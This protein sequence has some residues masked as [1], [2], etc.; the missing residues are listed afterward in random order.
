MKRG[1][2]LEV[3]YETT[4]PPI[5]LRKAICCFT[6]YLTRIDGSWLKINGLK[7]RP[8]SPGFITLH[9]V[10]NASSGSVKRVNFV[11]YMEKEKVFNGCFRRMGHAEDWKMNCESVLETRLVG[12]E[13]QHAE[14]CVV[15][16]GRGKV[17]MMS[18]FQEPQ[19]Q[20]IA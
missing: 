13:L 3:V 9:M 18:L 19:A 6:C 4:T 7:I 10:V 2:K 12:V 11:V 17:V 20:Q 16:E 14:L 15:V 8:N 1:E 5:G